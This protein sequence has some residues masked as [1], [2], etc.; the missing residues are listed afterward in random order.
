M[1]F[2]KLLNFLL[3]KIIDQ[4]LLVVVAKWPIDGVHFQKITKL[5]QLYCLVTYAQG[6]HGMGCWLASFFKC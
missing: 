6:V 2:T 5:A 4:D 1:V 3:C